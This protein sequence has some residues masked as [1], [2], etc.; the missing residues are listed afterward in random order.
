MVRVKEIY[1]WT[2]YQGKKSI[3]KDCVEQ[4]LVINCVSGW[5]YNLMAGLIV[6]RWKQNFNMN[7]YSYIPIEIEIDIDIEMIIQKDNLHIN[8]SLNIS[9]SL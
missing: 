2:L 5:Q 3:Y 8:F 4:I 9:Q 7:C 6:S 1:N